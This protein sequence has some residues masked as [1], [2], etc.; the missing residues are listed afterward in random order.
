LT[1]A[2]TSLITCDGKARRLGEQARD[3]SPGVRRDPSASRSTRCWAA[4]RT[5]ESS[6]SLSTGAVPSSPPPSA[7]TGSARSF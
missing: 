7:S 1:G 5:G 2:R 6:C 4:S 3:T